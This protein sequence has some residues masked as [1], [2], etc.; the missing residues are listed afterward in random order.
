MMQTGMMKVISGWPIMLDAAEPK[1][2]IR[3]A[4]LVPRLHKS[5]QASMRLK[6]FPM[7]ELLW[8]PMIRW[9]M[10]QAMTEPF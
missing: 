8:G 1:N 5:N 4:L 6:S 2:M 7:A 10:Y 9:F 3:R